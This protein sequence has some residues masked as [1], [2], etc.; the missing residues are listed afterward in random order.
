M[1]RSRQT[2]IQNGQGS[3]ASP[4]RCL[5]L[6]DLLFEPGINVIPI[7]F[8]IKWLFFKNWKLQSCRGG[9]WIAGISQA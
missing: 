9:I 5:Q 1:I 7:E 6:F 2:T 8:K 4:A 3:A